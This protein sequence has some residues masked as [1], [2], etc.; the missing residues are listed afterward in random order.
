R[1]EELFGLDT[2]LSPEQRRKLDYLDNLVDR[3]EIYLVGFGEVTMANWGK[4][5]QY[6]TE[7]IPTRRATIGYKGEE[8]PVLA[9]IDAHNLLAHGAR[10]MVATVINSFPLHWDNRLE[11]AFERVERIY[12]ELHIPTPPEGSSGGTDVIYLP[13]RSG[14]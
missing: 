3:G 9:N 2:L 14:E 12:S 1:P 13:A 7:R 8:T 10:A 6:C 5:Y 4:P 11:L